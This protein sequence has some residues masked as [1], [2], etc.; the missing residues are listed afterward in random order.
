[1]APIVELSGP[2]LPPSLGDLEDPPK[3]LYVAGELPRGPSVAIVGTR[4][5]T[6]EGVTFAREIAVELASQG[7][8]IVSGG[9]AGIDRAAHEGALEVGGTTVVVGPSSFDFPYPHQHRALFEAIV[10]RGGAH[11]S[12][13]RQGVKPHRAQFFARNGVLVAL[14]HVLVLV[15]SRVRGGARNAAKWAR[16]LS[17]PLLA[18]PG[19]PWRPTASGCLLEIRAGARVF[20]S[21]RD[22]L[23]ILDDQHRH[24]LPLLPGAQASLFPEPEGAPRPAD[25]MTDSSGLSDLDRVRRCLADGPLYPDGICEATGLPAPRVHELLLTLT[26]DGALATHPAGWVKLVT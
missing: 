7:I 8:A 1:M 17:R 19:P 5:P 25:L 18:V 21:S 2:K 11:V 23:R 6:L 10:E 20:M 12:L 3:R 9:A 22:V 13:H 24:P 4:K 26:L 14:C 16:E 15:E